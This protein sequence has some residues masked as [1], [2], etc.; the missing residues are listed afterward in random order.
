MLRYKL[1]NS[2]I[3]SIISLC[4]CAAVLIAACLVPVFSVGDDQVTIDTVAAQTSTFD[5]YSTERGQLRSKLISELKDIIYDEST[6]PE[7]L[8]TAQMSLIKNMEWM[9]MEATLEDII[10]LKGYG[11]AIVTIHQD[12]VNILIRKDELT[13]SQTAAILELACRETGITSG[14]IKIIPITY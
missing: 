12:S 6:S 10:A 7:V 11:E 4:V 13:Q 2:G 14:N 1:P 3:I 9:E 5:E 8:A